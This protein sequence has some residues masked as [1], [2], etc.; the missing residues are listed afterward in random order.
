L[1]NFID[2]VDVRLTLCLWIIGNVWYEGDP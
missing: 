1:I 2:Y